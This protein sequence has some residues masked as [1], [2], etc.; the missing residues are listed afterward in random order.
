MKNHPLL[1]HF[2]IPLL[3]SWE[4]FFEL[5]IPFL[6]VNSEA[7]NAIYVPDSSIVRMV[8]FLG[9]ILGIIGYIFTLIIYLLLGKIIAAIICAIVLV[10]C[11]ELL[12]QG[13]ETHNLI[14]SLRNKLLVPPY[15]NND[16]LDNEKSS[17]EFINFYIYA[18]V[19]VIRIIALIFIIYNFRFAW[20]IIVPVLEL[21]LQAYMASGNDKG[22]IKNLFYVPEKEITI[23]WI[24]AAII[25][26]IFGCFYI[27]LTIIA[28]LVSVLITSKVK[29]LLKSKNN[30]TAINIGITG[31]SMEI[32][33]LLIGLLFWIK[34]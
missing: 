20:I 3:K 13:E 5:P 33:L 14:I 24:T 29:S 19:Y 28:I 10:L 25:C 31:K 34:F 32:L 30:L 17:S 18:C 27:L 7:L 8:P 22:K 6:N 16:L 15:K 2:L 4:T 12:T 1:S 23:M 11:W 9:L 26:L 21:T